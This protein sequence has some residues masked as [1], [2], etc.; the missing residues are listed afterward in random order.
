MLVLAR[1]IG[2]QIVL[3]GYGV[4]I[5]IVG[6]TKSQVRIGI[7]APS[8]VP[9]YRR[10]ILDRIDSRCESQSEGK[11]DGKK[12]LVGYAEEPDGPNA[13]VVSPPELNACL[14]KWIAHRTSGR[15]C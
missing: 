12:Q 2:Q 7:E 10:E 8:Y 13:V 6:L 5:D 11:A 1:R 15:I 9:V 3:P 4:T 14:A